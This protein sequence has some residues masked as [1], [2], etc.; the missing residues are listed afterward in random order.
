ML[1]RTE[2]R[3][4]HRREIAGFYR[5]VR[6]MH[7]AGVAQKNIAEMVGVTPGRVSQILNGYSTAMDYPPEAL[8]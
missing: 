5:H 6:D 4:R 7:A 2:L 8:N 3:E 1:T